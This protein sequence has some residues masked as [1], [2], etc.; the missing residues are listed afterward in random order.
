AARGLV[1][2]E[3]DELH[4]PNVVEADD[5]DECIRVRLLGLLELLEHLGGVGAPE[6]GQ[7]PHGPVPAVVVSR[8]PVVLTVDK[9]DLAEL[10]AGHPLGT[11]QVLDLLQE[12]LHGERWQVGE[13]LELLDALNRPHLNE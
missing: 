4:L 5:T 7:L 9:S 6:H 13:G 3:A 12:V 1:G 10:E 8:G 11:E 2:D